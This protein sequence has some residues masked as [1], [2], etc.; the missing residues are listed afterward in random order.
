MPPFP[1][2]LRAALGQREEALRLLLAEYDAYAPFAEA[3]GRCRTTVRGGRTLALDEDGR[4]FLRR[5]AHRWNLDRVAHLA[6]GDFHRLAQAADADDP[7]LA[8]SVPFGDWVPNDPVVTVGGQR[9]LWQVGAGESLGAFRARIRCDLRL[10]DARQLPAEL[11]AAL[12]KLPGQ[13]RDAGWVLDDV[14]SALPRHIGWL[15]QRL[16]PQ[17]DRPRSAA[18]IAEAESLALLDEAAL[19]SAIEAPPERQ[20]HRDV[21][22]LA[23]SLA[24]ELPR[25][26]TRRRHS[27]V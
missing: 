1:G 23:R 22:N 21:R 27:P 13:A 10:K 2:H 15:F 17:P 4:L 6:E 12:P 14:Q 7:R 18:Q 25:L 20:V 8:W 3:W 19:D 5:L 24:I 11:Q 16:C 26:S 9:W